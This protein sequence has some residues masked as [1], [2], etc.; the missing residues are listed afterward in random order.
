MHYPNTGSLKETE[1][2]VYP[3]YESSS[4]QSCNCEGVLT[5]EIKTVTSILKWL[6]KMV[7]DTKKM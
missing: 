2:E 4:C 3:N 7:T 1:K 6:K 5:S